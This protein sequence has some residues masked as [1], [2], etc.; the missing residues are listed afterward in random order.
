MK[1]FPR[2][3]RD[4]LH[5]SPLPLDI[6]GNCGHLEAPQVHIRKQSKVD[7]RRYVF[8]IISRTSDNQS[9]GTMTAVPCPVASNKDLSSSLESQNSFS[10]NSQKQKHRTNQFNCDIA[11][12][13][14][15]R[16]LLRPLFD[17]SM[18][19]CYIR[20]NLGA[21]FSISRQNLEV[22]RV[23]APEISADFGWRCSWYL[24]GH[25]DRQPSIA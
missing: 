8:N 13:K 21:V 15:D 11:W 5:D 9:P 3:T 4:L 18:K 23:Q 25:V 24:D 19:A 17:K 2:K 10:R 6:N 14:L 12:P 16:N 22:F 7:G 1:Q 20:R